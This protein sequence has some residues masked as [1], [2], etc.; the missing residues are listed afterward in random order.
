MTFNPYEEKR[1]PSK[2][3][4]QQ[5]YASLALI[6][7]RMLDMYFTENEREALASVI[8]AVMRE[9]P[10]VERGSVA[11]LIRMIEKIAR[12]TDA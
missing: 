7:M 11:T 5:E 9:A 4:L 12:S 6:V 10:K 3:E 2:G 8:G 1:P